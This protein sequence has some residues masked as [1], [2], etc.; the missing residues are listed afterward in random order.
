MSEAQRSEYVADRPTSN[1]NEPAVVAT[2]GVLLL[3]NTHKVS[4]LYRDVQILG[5]IA[6]SLCLEEFLRTVA[7]QKPRTVLVCLHHVVGLKATR[8]RLQ[9][10]SRTPRLL[11]Y[12]VAQRG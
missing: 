10:R 7:Y 3:D 8:T 5:C 6:V 9:V 12:G 2:H 4:L 1:I 11:K